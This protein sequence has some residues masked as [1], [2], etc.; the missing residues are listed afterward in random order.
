MGKAD[1]INKEREIGQQILLVK[2]IKSINR[3]N[4]STGIS[5][6]DKDDIMEW[7]SL[8]KGDVDKLINCCAALDDYRLS[9]DAAIQL[10]LAHIFKW[11]ENLVLYTFALFSRLGWLVATQFNLS[12]LSNYCKN[13]AND[14]YIIY[15][16][17][18]PDN[19]VSTEL[20][21]PEAMERGILFFLKYFVEQIDY[22]N[23]NGFHW[24]VIKTM[25]G[26]EITEE[27]VNQIRAFLELKKE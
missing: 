23:S 9:F 25:F 4:L 16:E 8:S 11:E 27:R 12:E 7:A 5:F 1:I 15:C 3:R 21:T 18:R 22:V 14:V 2:I 20:T 26:H 19:P 24:D 17:R 13:S 6:I 10:E